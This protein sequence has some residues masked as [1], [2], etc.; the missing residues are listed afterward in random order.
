[1]YLCNPIIVG[2][3]ENPQR[4]SVNSSLPLWSLRFVNLC[5][6]ADGE[7]ARFQVRKPGAIGWR[8]IRR[9]YKTF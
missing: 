2:P 6:L 7:S 4:Q 3:Y 9:V 5:L 1:M 8:H